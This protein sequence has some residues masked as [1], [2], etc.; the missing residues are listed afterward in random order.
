[1][2]KIKEYWKDGEHIHLSEVK[3]KVCKEKAGIYILYCVDKD[4][5]GKHIT[6]AKEIDKSG[7][8]YIG[9]SV[10]LW[11]R[12]SML[13]NSLKQGCSCRGFNVHPAMQ[14]YH[15]YGYEGKFPENKLSIL[16]EYCNGKKAAH[17]KEGEI[18][19]AYRGKHLDSPPLNKAE[20]V[21]KNHSCKKGK[22]IKKK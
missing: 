17:V 6:R 1:M 4:G 18:L 3:D 21:D 16:F 13:L 14:L 11:K 22:H 7:I 2:K 15:R 9:H 8:L 19:K 12:L 5:K 20:P 10:N